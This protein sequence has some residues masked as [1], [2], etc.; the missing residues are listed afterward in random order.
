[1][2]LL[3]VDVT[4]FGVVMSADS[5][6]VEIVDG[7]TPVI[8]TRGRQRRNPI[9]TR[10]GGGFVGLIGFAGT[11]S[12][13]SIPTAEWIRR[14]SVE[15]AAD[16]ID[17]FCERLG[18]QLTSVWRRQNVPT[19]LEILIGGEVSGDVQF[20]YVRNSAGL[21]PDGLHHGPA[22]QFAVENDLDRNYIPRDAAP[23]EAKDDVLGR[24]MYSFR[25]GVL[26]P[27]SPVFD[28]F[29][30]LMGLLYGAGVQGF[31]PLASLDDVGQYARVRMEFLKRLC[32]S[33][34][35]IYA[36]Q[37]DP[38]IAGDVHVYGVTRKGEVREYVKGRHDVRT[39]RAGR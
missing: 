37:I 32:T 36:P 4:A 24:N 5:Q 26:L 38:P 20:W 19:V 30:Q 21:R 39:I 28:G 35:G 27:A 3:A 22:A 6:L 17:S 31:S 13:E 16:E 18:K 14:F 33:K 9:T 11:E 23:G 12:I 10:V 7:E 8:H 1:M 34:Y 15:S 2:G 25:Q 29:A